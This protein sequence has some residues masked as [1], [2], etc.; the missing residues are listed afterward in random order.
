MLPEFP[1]RLYDGAAVRAD[2]GSNLGASAQSVRR[3]I[4]IAEMQ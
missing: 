1:A 3:P 2:E 4:I